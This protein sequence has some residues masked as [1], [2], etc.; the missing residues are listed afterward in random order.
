MP[1]WFAVNIFPTLELPGIDIVP[2]ETGVD[3]GL[4]VASTV[5]ATVKGVC[6]VGAT[7]AAGSTGAALATW[8]C[9]VND[10]WALKEKPTCPFVE[11]A[12]IN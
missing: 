8:P 7:V 6:I 2:R 1:L 5:G 12:E 4:T 10:L 9:A 11:L 3:V